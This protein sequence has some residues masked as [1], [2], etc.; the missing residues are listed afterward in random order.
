MNQ[1]KKDYSDIEDPL[2]SIA[3][4]KNYSLHCI[5]NIGSLQLVWLHQVKFHFAEGLSKFVS[6]VSK[7]GRALV[8]IVPEYLPTPLT[9]YFDGLL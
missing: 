2:P 4:K 7:G 8:L 3:K 9:A 6:K 1:I 5:D